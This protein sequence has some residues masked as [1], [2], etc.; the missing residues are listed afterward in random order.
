MDNLQADQAFAYQILKYE[1]RAIRLTAADLG[2]LSLWKSEA[3]CMEPGVI[4]DENVDKG[5]KI[6]GKLITFMGIVHEETG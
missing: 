3:V 2:C 1:R 4:P 6:V 5:L